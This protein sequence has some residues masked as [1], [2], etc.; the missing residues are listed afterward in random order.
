MAKIIIY[1]DKIPP[2]HRFYYASMTFNA[3]SLDNG[4][5]DT[6]VKNSTI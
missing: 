4:I 2:F 5:N 3:I 1:S 6:I